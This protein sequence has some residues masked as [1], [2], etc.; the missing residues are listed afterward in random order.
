MDDKCAE[1]A[2]NAVLD[3][4]VRSTFKDDCLE[5]VRRA[6][7]RTTWWCVAAGILAVLHIVSFVL[8][9]GR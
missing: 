6:E 5:A 3:K 2:L 9:F 4:A 7:N 8:N 1:A